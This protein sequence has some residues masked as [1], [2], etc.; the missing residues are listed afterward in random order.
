MIRTKISQARS[1][2]FERKYPEAPL[3]SDA[4]HREIGLV[5]GQNSFDAF[6]GGKKDQ[7]GAGEVHGAIGVARERVDVALAS[8]SAATRRLCGGL[9]GCAKDRGWRLG[10]ADSGCGGGTLLL[11]LVLKGCSDECREQRMGLERFGLE[12]RV[13]LAAEKPG[14][15]RHFH[16]FNVVFV[17]GAAGDS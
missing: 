3:A 6:A 8:E 12:F 10:F 16:N 1:R 17:R 7:C 14:M 15:I 4:I 2:A 9:G 5:H 11:E 13:E